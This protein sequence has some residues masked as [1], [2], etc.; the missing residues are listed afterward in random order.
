MTTDATGADEGLDYV[1]QLADTMQSG[2]AIVAVSKKPLSALYEDLM[3][4]ITFAEEGQR[5][6]ALELLEGDV[7]T[8]DSAAVTTLRAK[9]LQH[10]ITPTIQRMTGDPLRAVEAF[11]KTHSSIEMIFLSPSLS[12][13]KDIKRILK[14]QLLKRIDKPVVTIRRLTETTT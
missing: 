1:L 2:I 3:S 14:Q 13:R 6:T 7:P 10:N 5:D 4:S 9:C 8:D 12:E 11:V